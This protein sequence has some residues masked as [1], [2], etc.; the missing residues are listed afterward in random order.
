MFKNVYYKKWPKGLNFYEQIKATS[1]K[2]KK[3]YGLVNAPYGYRKWDNSFH[4]FIDSAESYVCDSE[5]EFYQILESHKTYKRFSFHLC[6]KGRF[7]GE[8][9]GVGIDFN[10][11]D[12]EVQAHSSRLEYIDHVISIIQTEFGLE[13]GLNIDV[14]TYRKKMLEPTIFISRHF[15]SDGDEYFRRLER[16]LEILGFNILQGEEYASSP[17]PEKVKHRIEKQDIMIVIVSGNREHDWLTAEIGF[18]LGKE[19]HIIILKEKDIEFNTT[20]I[21]KDFEYIPLG[22][23]AIDIA[24][25][26]LLS[27]FRQIGIKGLFN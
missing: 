9:Y 26:R 13:K 6:L 14:D 12:I 16:P 10:G 21:G 11:T 20:I 27:E 5:K 18:G 23:D 15:D 2:I 22:T 19:K 24:L 7:F 3:E 17:I 1:A 8:R 4:V 25:S